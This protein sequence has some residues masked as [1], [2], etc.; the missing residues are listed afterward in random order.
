MKK[1]RLSRSTVL[2]SVPFE[3]DGVAYEGNITE[4]PNALEDVNSESGTTGR[5]FRST[6]KRMTSQYLQLRVMTHAIHY[7]GV[8]L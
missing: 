2:D 1:A 8:R 5:L 6:G 4:E 3:D 7:P